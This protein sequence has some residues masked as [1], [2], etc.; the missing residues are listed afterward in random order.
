MCA[1]DETAV[2]DTDRVVKTDAPRVV[3]TLLRVPSHHSELFSLVM[4][5]LGANMCVT[6]Q[7][8][9]T[10]IY[11]ASICLFGMLLFLLSS[12]LRLC[13]EAGLTT[14]KSIP[15]PTGTVEFYIWGAVTDFWRKR[16]S[17]L[18]VAIVVMGALSLALFGFWHF[19]KKTDP[20]LSVPTLTQQIDSQKK[21][22]DKLNS[23]LV[24]KNTKLQAISAIIDANQSP[25]SNPKQKESIKTLKNDLADAKSKLRMI[26]N[27][28]GKTR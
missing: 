11:G 22:I 16:K 5:S 15:L 25:P 26:R 24:D 23:D 8:R 28:I 17:D 7:Y 2:Q 10:V 19:D 3:R 9:A 1:N 20:P 21:T 6:A 13:R 4:L 18:I 27:K 12:F 14:M